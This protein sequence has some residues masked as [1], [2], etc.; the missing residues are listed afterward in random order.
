MRDRRRAPGLRFERDEARLTTS[1]LSHRLHRPHAHDIIDHLVRQRRRVADLET[2][3]LVHRRQNRPATEMAKRTYLG[4]S[5]IINAGAHGDPSGRG[6][7]SRS[8][9]RL[10]R[11]QRMP[12]AVI[13]AKLPYARDALGLLVD[14]SDAK[15]LRLHNIAQITK[16]F[17]VLNSFREEVTSQHRLA[18]D[19]SF[20]LIDEISMPMRRQLGANHAIISAIE[21]LKNAAR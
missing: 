12:D 18:Y 21:R 5:T 9:P 14:L 10:K 19:N 2:R 16:W 20:R 17:S 15:K 4:G 6:V 11:S 13:A 7:G 8:S 3:P 1:I